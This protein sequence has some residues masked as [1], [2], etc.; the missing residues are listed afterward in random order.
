[1]KNGS[2]RLPILR[3]RMILLMKFKNLKK[4]CIVI[5]SIIATPLKHFNSVAYSYHPGGFDDNGKPYHAMID[6]M[7]KN[8][9]MVKHLRYEHDNGKNWLFR[10]RILID[11][12]L[13]E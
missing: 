7:E 5:D 4:N 10:E 2:V 6:F 9:G 12:S 11:Y 13:S 3:V 8:I 1:M